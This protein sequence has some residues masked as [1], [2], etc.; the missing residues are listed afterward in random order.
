[1]TDTP[2]AQTG[3][4]TSKPRWRLTTLGELG[5]DMPMGIETGGT[6]LKAFASKPWRMKEEKALGKF[7]EENPGQPIGAFVGKI[8]STLLTKLGPHQWNDSTSDAEKN[9]VISQL[10][11]GDV[12]YIY[13]Y[14][15]KVALGRTIPTTLQCPACRRKNERDLDLDGLDV[16][17]VDDPSQLI[18]DVEL[19]DGVRVFG[20]IRKRLRVRPPRWHVMYSPGVR[21]ENEAE[22]TVQLIKECVCGAEGVDPK[23]PIALLDNDIDELSKADIVTL[24]TAIENTAGPQ[25]VVEFRCS[26]CGTEIRQMVDYRYENFFTIPSR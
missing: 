24:E 10:Y 23:Q 20:E 26:G 1:M 4:N 6:L 3:E 11:L 9:L 25:M 17:V 22:R 7:R 8:L 18:G 19:R 2:K 13:A 15:R 21:T 14:L 5:A 12:L 16:R